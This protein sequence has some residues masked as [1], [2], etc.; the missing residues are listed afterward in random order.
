MSEKCYMKDVDFAINLELHEDKRYYLKFPE[1]NF[2]ETFGMLEQYISKHDFELFQI[3]GL[4][5]NDINYLIGQDFNI[6]S[7]LNIG[8]NL[9]YICGVDSDTFEF[10]EKASGFLTGGTLR[11]IRAFAKGYF[12]YA[13]NTY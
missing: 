11:E 5:S 1:T 12:E 9:I 13:M 2:S 10:K 4:I 6:S 3:R 7:F 8:S